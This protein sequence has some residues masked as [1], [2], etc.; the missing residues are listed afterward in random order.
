MKHDIIFCGNKKLLLKSIPKIKLHLPSEFLRCF[1]IYPEI[2]SMISEN[3][4]HTLKL[5][6]WDQNKYIPANINLFK[7]LTCLLLRSLAMDVTL[8]ALL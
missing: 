2:L 4:N 3:C 7:A 8:S 1:P 5:Y 6:K